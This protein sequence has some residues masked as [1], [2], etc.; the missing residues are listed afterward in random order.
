MNPF[1]V[2]GGRAEDE[3]ERARIA[4]IAEAGEV[5]SLVE[6]LPFLP[7][8][9]HRLGTEAAE[10]AAAVLERC[11]PS[12]LAWFDQWYRGGWLPKGPPA[13]AWRDVRLGTLSWARQF[14]G[15]VALASFHGNGFVREVAVRLLSELDDGFELPYLLIRTNDWVPKVRVAAATAALKR[16]TASHIEHWLRCLGLLDRL[17]MAQRRDRESAPYVGRVE[18]LLLHADAR[19][20]L[21]SALSTGE[22]TVRRAVLRLVLRLP[23]GERRR[24]LM[25]A[26]RD[27]D[28]LI[29]FDA[30][31]GLL[32]N[33][34]T[35]ESPSAVAQLVHHRLARIRGLA[36]AAAVEQRVP[37]ATDW[38]ERA[39]FDEARSVREVG[40][41]ELSKLE[42]GDRDFAATYRKRVSESA[43]RDRAVALEGLAEVGT[44]DDIEVF[45]QFL[46]DP[47]A[48]M[49]AAAIAGIGRCN[50]ERHLDDLEAALRDASSTVRRAATRFAKLY[51]GRG[52]VKRV[53]QE[54]RGP[55]ALA[56]DRRS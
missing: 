19:T 27:A 34:T 26:V 31:K 55:N 53:R 8:E 47:N 21:E 23:S 3:E 49:R 7:P 37:S 29:A 56:P 17:R 20:P 44:Q 1:R 12:Q 38:L 4:L 13:P 36:L 18:E 28:P 33:T 2:L 54:L 25:T 52:P 11:S 30:A 39:V 32:S 40:R 35:D 22:L 24:L 6:L 42:N 16:V 10:A 48:R 51:L 45:R 46:H 9:A 15:V 50:G 43:D 41:H 5:R 14:R